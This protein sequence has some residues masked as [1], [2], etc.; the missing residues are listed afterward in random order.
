MACLPAR[1]RLCIIL[2]GLCS[3][4]PCVPSVCAFCCSMFGQLCINQGTEVEIQPSKIFRTHERRREK[5]NA[6]REVRGERGVATSQ[7]EIV[8]KLEEAYRKLFREEELDDRSIARSLHVMRTVCEVTAV[9]HQPMAVLQLDLHK[10]FYR[11]SQKFFLAPLDHFCVGET[12]P[13]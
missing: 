3:S 4:V 12:L 8:A 1:R 10:A 7:E 6:P 11:V 5:K 2:N 13:E 9:G